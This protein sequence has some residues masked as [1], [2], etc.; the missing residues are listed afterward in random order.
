MKTFKLLMLTS[1]MC[2]LANTAL[3]VDGTINFSGEIVGGTCKVTA[4]AGTSVSGDTLGDYKVVVPLGKVGLES[5]KNDGITASRAIHLDVNCENLPTTISAVKINFDPLSGS[6]IDEGDMNLLKITGSAKGVGIALYDNE[7]NLINMAAN[8]SVSDM[9]E[10]ADEGAKTATLSMR[11]GFKT[12]G[13]ELV[14]GEAVGTLPF[15]LTYE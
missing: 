9:F 14:A 12:N 7:N 5:L 4:G 8:E 1:A 10:G 2:A 13:E 11:A 3:A 6:G 15:T